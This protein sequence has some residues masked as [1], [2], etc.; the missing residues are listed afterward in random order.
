MSAKGPAA[1][2][3]ALCLGGLGV[4]T[5]WVGWSGLQAAQAQADAV[6]SLLAVAKLA[7]GQERDAALDAAQ[8]ALRRRL[9]YRPDDALAW[10]RLAEVR[11]L[12]AMSGAVGQLSPEL[13]SASL[14]ADARVQA[15]GGSNARDF[16]R[17]S[18]A[19][20]L[21]GGARAQEGAEWL[22]S[23]YRLEGSAT[24]LA[25]RRLAAGA[26]LWP[27]LDVRTR[28][29]VRKEAC[30]ALRDDLLL[31]GDAVAVPRQPSA[32][33]ADGS[34]NAFGPGSV[35]LTLVEDLCARDV[36]AG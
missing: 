1:A 23:S 5:T 32:T 36:L 8:V 18:Y 14:D 24:G 15:L 30:G 17:R 4:W 7:V 21:L 26:Q 12:Q 35:R 25:P 27:S 19:A 16:A 2:A 34:A 28:A 13:V 9:E 10:S 6:R 29:A 11:L 33:G 22:A 20:S 3:A 31:V